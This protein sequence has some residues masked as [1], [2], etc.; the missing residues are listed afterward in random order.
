[1]FLSAESILLQHDASHHVI[2][3]LFIYLFMRVVIKLERT[4]T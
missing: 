3:L 2:L 4:T 1:M